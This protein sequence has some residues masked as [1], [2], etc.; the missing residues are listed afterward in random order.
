MRCY[1]SKLHYLNHRLPLGLTEVAG[2]HRSNRLLDFRAYIN[3]TNTG[4]TRIPNTNH[5]IKKIAAYQRR[6]I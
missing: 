1:Q 6:A 3:R 4:Q 2:R 5:I